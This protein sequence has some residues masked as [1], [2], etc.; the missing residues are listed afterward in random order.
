VA[1]SVVVELEG[2]L[3]EGGA[4]RVGGLEVDAA[5]RLGGFLAL[6]LPNWALLMS[7]DRLVGESELAR[8]SSR[9]MA[10]SL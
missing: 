9:V 2:E 1:G 3:A 10:L 4:V 6:P 7:Q 8:A 5:G